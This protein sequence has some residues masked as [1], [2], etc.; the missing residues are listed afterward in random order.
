MRTIIK[1]LLSWLF[2][3][4][5]FSYAQYNYLDWLK[6]QQKDFSRFIEED[7]EAYQRFK[8]KQDS[9]FNDFLQ[10]EWRAIKLLKGLEPDKT[11]KPIVIPITSPK[12]I[13]KEIL[14]EP[15]LL[16]KETPMLKPP[17][18]NESESMP[19]FIQKITRGKEQLSFIF[20]NVLLKVNYDNAI[21]NADLKEILSEVKIK[22]FLTD[23]NCCNYVDLLFQLIKLKEIM[24]L[25]D[26]G[27]FLL[28]DNIA[29]QI[30]PGSE[31]KQYLFI[32][33]M[34]V[35]SGYDAKFNYNDD[36]EIYLSMS[37]INKI[38]KSQ[39]S[40]EGNKSYYVLTFNNSQKRFK[41]GYSYKGNY[42]GAEKPISLRIENTPLI[43]KAFEEKILKFSY[44]KEY[45]FI[46]KLRRDL[47][48]FYFN[49]PQTDY[50]VYFD[51]PLSYEAYF[52]LLTAL[53]P[54]L[55]GKSEAEAVN[56]LL[57][58]VQNA[59]EY[60]TDTDQ[61]GREKPFFAEETLFYPYSDCEDRS[62]L[63]AYLVHQLL[64]LQVIGLDYNGEPGHVSTA[65]KFS[66]VIDG[67]YIKFNENKFIICDAT[68]INANIGNSMPEFRNR[69]ARLIF[70]A[71]HY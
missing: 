34:L 30:Y 1:S 48:D 11:P 45:E 49:Y 46:V 12:D 37:S 6:K 42:P 67:D 17:L 24:K 28:L 32:W 7:Q 43:R 41:S 8:A 2:L 36:N 60:K 52:S 31:N 19:D 61:F 58:F 54:I 50:N 68:Y 65:V 56:I 66:T 18:I 44:D 13:P 47:I 22:E 23:L 15:S 33:F 57:R 55:V 69:K 53:R 35:N 21:L 20:F 5:S 3:T 26:W 62:V 64:G 10:K 14:I 25:N 38:Y 63:F 71:S 70:P 29:D 4:F 9:A 40:T 27:Y 39:Y 59:F 51:A 16:I